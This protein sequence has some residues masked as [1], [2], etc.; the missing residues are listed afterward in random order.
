MKYNILGKTG[1]K[2]SNLGFGAMRLPTKEPGKPEINVEEAVNIIRK[3]IDAGINYVDTAYNYHDFK[4]ELAVAEALKEGYR[5]KITLVT[6]SPIWYDQFTTPEHFEK[7]LNHSLE[8]LGVDYL[9]IYLLH[10]VRKNRW[11]EVVVPFKIIQRAMKAKEEG[12]FRFL[13]LS[14]HDTP[15]FLKEILE[16]T[17]AEYFDVLL[18]QY[19]LLDK[20]YEEVI[21]LAAKKGLGIAVMGPNGGG[22]LAGEPPKDMYN[23]LTPG[24][25]NF[26]DL[27][28]K[29][30]WS[31]PNIDIALSGMGSEAMVDDNIS[32]ANSDTISLNEE[33]KLRAEK[34]IAT[35]K[36]KTNNICTS[37]NYCMP[38]PNEVNISF[39]FRALILHEVYG[40]K[41]V[42]KFYYSKIGE[43]DWP[44]G[45]RANACVECGE[46]LE[47]CPQKIPI[48]EQLNVAHKILS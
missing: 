25:N 7:Y 20:Q 12:K 48:I 16:L 38:C 43:K 11:D 1:I 40:H 13:G 36:E 19:N 2:V 39:I 32:I 21:E 6:K 18:I 3:G 33:E 47:K 8:K 42:A 23:L 24:R 4:S 34:I 45:K 28:L 31:N 27:A 5:E 46:C 10:S 41:D 44:P 29:F 14:F 22:R 30:V 15:E 17:E 37:C 26:V 35:F 9:D